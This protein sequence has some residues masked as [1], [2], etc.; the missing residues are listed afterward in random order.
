[1]C[2]ALPCLLPLLLL[3]LRCGRHAVLHFARC[4]AGSHAL[5]AVR[6]AP[7]PA[8][9]QA[10]LLGALGAPA[11]YRFLPFFGLAWWLVA[12]PREEGGS[13]DAAAP[14]REA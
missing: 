14:E 2:A 13:S 8:V 4:P 9:W 7:A 12:G 3:P 6:A 11:K 1:M 10:W 5:R